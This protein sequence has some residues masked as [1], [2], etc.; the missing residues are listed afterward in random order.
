MRLISSLIDL[1]SYLVAKKSS[2]FCNFNSSGDRLIVCAVACILF[3]VDTTATGV[4][5]TLS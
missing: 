1:I 5:Q 2:L 4:S 3:V